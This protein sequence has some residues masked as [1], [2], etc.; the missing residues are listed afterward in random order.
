MV[1]ENAVRDNTK[2]KETNCGSTSSEDGLNMSDETNFAGD[3]TANQLNQLLISDIF[4]DEVRGR[5]E[6]PIPLTL[7]GVMGATQ[8]LKAVAI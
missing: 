1:Y 6:D 7:T 8:Q 4:P 3:E 2:K 5:A